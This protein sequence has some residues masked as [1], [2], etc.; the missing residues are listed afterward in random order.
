M[1]SVGFGCSTANDNAKYIYSHFSCFVSPW[2][3]VI[4]KGLL[5]HGLP[6]IFNENFDA[7]VLV[8]YNCSGY[9]FY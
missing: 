3:V 6:Y 8:G 9:I 7:N 4:S 2:E 1:W 5:S